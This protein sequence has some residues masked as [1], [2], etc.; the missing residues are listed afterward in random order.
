[1]DLFC[2]KLL[3]CVRHPKIR[4]H[5]SPIMKFSII[6]PSYNQGIYLE[7]CILSVKHQK[8]M[9]IE[10]EHIIIDGGSTD[11]TLKILQKYQSDI[12]YYVSE[13]DSG[14]SEAINKGLQRATGDII[15]W[16]NADDYYTDDALTV[17]SK[18]FEKKLTLCVMGTCRVF[19]HGQN[20]KKAEITS[21]TD[22]YPNNFP[23]TIG[24]ART[25]QPS[26]FYHK[27]AIKKM[28]NVDENLHYIMDR[29]WWIKYLYSFGFQKNCIQKT[30]E[31]L[32]NFRLH[33]TSKSVKDTH[34][35][36]YE[37]D[38]YYHALAKLNRNRNIS[39]FLAQHEKF[40]LKYEIQN[41]E[42]S[43][44]IFI[45]YTYRALLYYIFA[46]ATE[47][48]AMRDFKKFEQYIGFFETEKGTM[49]LLAGYDK[50]MLKKI[51]FRY[52]NYP[53]FLIKCWDWVRKLL[54]R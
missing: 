26:T 46:R 7:Q 22:F 54:F 33:S 41:I 36:Q 51:K 25:D 45:K 12:A 19:Y 2:G 20:P 1:M 24:I 47:F 44:P 4:L 8:N 15:N 40:D 16:L 42:F 14:Q 23:K 50:N 38:A 48:Y 31:V 53:K 11:N 32:V 5:Y 10:V 3:V 6:T 9:G 30:P 39:D 35:F 28:G 49:D 43:H 29:D 34:K 52:E 27:E 21:G 37:R 18:L 17:V 13:N